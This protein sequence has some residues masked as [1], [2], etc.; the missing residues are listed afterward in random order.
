[1]LNWLAKR[2]RRKRNAHNLYGSIVALSRSP[3]L[4]TELGVPD[5]L[6]TRFEI[7]VMHMFIF[8]NRM[9][10]SGEDEQELAQEIVDLFFADMD[11]TSREAGVGD[12]AVPKRMRK[13]AA[14]FQERMTQYNQAIN[15]SNREAI[16]RE[17]KQNIYHGNESVGRHAAGLS[18]YVWTLKSE[19]AQMPTNELQFAH[20]RLTGKMDD[21]HG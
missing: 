13:L 4:Y 1:M 18:E 20:E 16:T 21:D 12:L 17:F 6:E 5:T 9:Q 15:T 3:I 10:G 2:S 7:L 11:T 8:I 14:V 19:L